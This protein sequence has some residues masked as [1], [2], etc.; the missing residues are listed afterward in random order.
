MICLNSEKAHMDFPWLKDINMKIIEFSKPTIFEKI[1]KKIPKVA[2]LPTYVTGYN[3]AFNRLVSDWRKGITK[4]LTVN[5]Y[6]LIIVLGTG[7]SFAPHFAM[8]E[9]DTDVKWIANIHDPYPM[10]HYPDPISIT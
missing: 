7:S 1:L 10:S 9:I 3:M 6:D 4:E 2:A 5:K 8:A